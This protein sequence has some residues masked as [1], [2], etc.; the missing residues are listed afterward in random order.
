MLHNRHPWA[1]GCCSALVALLM[2]VQ[3][4]AFAGPA[5][6]LADDPL[7]SPG[8][9]YMLARFLGDAPVQFDSRVEV[10]APAAAEDVMAVPVEVRVHDLPNVKQILVFADLNPLPEILRYY[11]QQAQ[12]QIGFRFKVEQSTPIRAAVLSDDGWHV[13]GVWLSASGGGCT[14]PSAATGSGLWQERLGEI[15]ARRWPQPAGQRVKLQVIH[16]M[17]TGLA[18]GIPRLFIE[19][20][21]LSDASGALLARIEPHEPIAENPVFSVDLNARG[22]VRIDG[23]DL[24]GNRFAAELQP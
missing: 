4:P 22:A 20:L 7:A 14:T 19:T 3:A 13:G 12:P 5:V 16:P 21:N 2:L 18:V 15:S 23:R 24:H 1:F 6:V 8:W 11:P 10:I 17:D 9:R